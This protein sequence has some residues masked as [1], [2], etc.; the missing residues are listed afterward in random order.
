MT[1]PDHAAVRSAA[2]AGL[3][4]VLLFLAANAPARSI[5]DF[6]FLLQR[7]PFSLPTAEESSPLAERFALTGAASW[8]GQERIFL[9][10]KNSHERH[11]IMSEPNR[12]G[13]RLLEFIPSADPQRMSA[14]VQIGAEVATLIFQAP[15]PPAGGV[16]PPGSPSVRP[17]MP[18]SNPAVQAGGGNQQTNPPRRIIRRRTISPRTNQLE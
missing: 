5:E 4:V 1:A 13:M 15:E 2:H 7:S 11:M 9:M 3:V 17:G 14:K 16:Q 18:N 12:L 10:E 8:D 6:D